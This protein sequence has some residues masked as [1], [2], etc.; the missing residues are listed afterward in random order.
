MSIKV[1]L[2]IIIEGW[3]YDEEELGSYDNLE[4]FV[5]DYIENFGLD[6]CICE[7]EYKILEIE[8]K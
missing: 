4:D 2:E 5:K 3:D 7:N 1:T 6:D 8:T